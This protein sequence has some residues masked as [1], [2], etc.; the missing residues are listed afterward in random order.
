[1]HDHL[2]EMSQRGLKYRFGCLDQIN[3]I[4]PFN[5]GILCTNGFGPA[6]E[7]ISIVLRYIYLYD[8]KN[9]LVANK[10]F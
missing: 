9:M 6:E 2:F 3:L 5:P 1:M 4:V 8:W 7:W 10:Y